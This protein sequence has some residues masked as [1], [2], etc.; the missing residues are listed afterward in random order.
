MPTIGS[1]KSSRTSEEIVRSATYFE[2]SVGESFEFGNRLFLL[3]QTA[4]L[5]R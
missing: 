3:I 2:G 1:E 5:H 4:L